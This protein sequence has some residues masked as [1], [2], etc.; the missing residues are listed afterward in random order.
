MLAASKT[1]DKQEKDWEVEWWQ[2]QPLLDGTPSRPVEWSTCSLI[3][4]A[5]HTDPTLTARHFSSSKQFTLPSPDNSNSAHFLAAFRPPSLISAAPTGDW[6]FAYYPGNDNENRCCLWKRG[7][8]IDS[9]SVK[10]FWHEPSDVI[11]AEWIGL[12]REWTVNADG[13]ASR[14]PPFGPQMP[15]LSP[16][17]I[18]IT[19]NN[20]L[21]LVYYRQYQMNMK[22][23]PMTLLHQCLNV[24]A[25]LVNDWDNISIPGCARLCAKA[26]IGVNYNDPGFMIATRVYRAPARDAESVAAFQHDDD[27]QNIDW[28]QWGEESNIQIAEGVIGFDGTSVHLALQMSPPIYPRNTTPVAAMAFANAV[29]KAA[30][31]HK[32][33][34]APGERFLVVS[35]LDFG[36]YT[37]PPK[38]E[39][40]SYSFTPRI[41]PLNRQW[42]AK[43]EVARSFH[44]D[45]VVSLAPCKAPVCG[46]YATVLHRSGKFPRGREQARIGQIMMLNTPDLSDSPNA[47][48]S[49]V[50]IP[51][52]HISRQLP[53]HAVM[54]PNGSLSCAVSSD[55][56]PT[57]INVY[58]LPR[59]STDTADKAPDSTDQEIGARPSSDLA[60]R[61]VSAI[62]SQ[63]R[64]G[65]LTHLLAVPVTPMDTVRD[66]LA[67]VLQLLV[68]NMGVW[69]RVDSQWAVLGLAVEV[70]RSRAQRVKDEEKTDF[71]LRWRAG[72][73]MCSLFAMQLA[74]EYCA[75]EEGKYD[76]AALWQLVGLCTWF[77]GYLERLMKV[78]VQHGNLAAPEKATE[79]DDLFG[80]LPSPATPSSCAPA[81]ADAAPSPTLLPFTHVALVETLSHVAQQVNKLRG[82][83]ETAQITDERSFMAKHVLVD[84][85]DCAG[86]SLKEM[87]P[88]LD[89][90]KTMVADSIDETQQRLSLV[91]CKPTHESRQT[92]HAIA[93]KITT[94]PVLDKMRLFIRPADLVDGM[95]SMSLTGFDASSLDDAGTPLPESSSGS[96]GMR[97]DRDR[98]VV[99]KAPLGQQPGGLVCLR[100]G[101]RSDLPSDLEDKAIACQGWR[102]WEGRWARECICGGAWIS[103]AHA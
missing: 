53:L 78:T 35:H 23:M 75:D 20:C 98:D 39:L 47:I 70:Y 90:V 2:F 41:L 72:R 21:K 16:A 58:T 42:E 59:C 86:V 4:T 48:P 44:P 80:S 96:S 11:A 26:A 40:V 18:L 43:E 7:S 36:D 63:R 49:P 56:M 24:E 103:A 79:E 10:D 91:S 87:E 28:E 17:L 33:S 100:C 30:E 55:L 64:T 57:R 71:G 65:D 46:I 89:E 12:P 66:T 62:Y 31:G 8:T 68:K 27:L 73:D 102:I 51:V 97:K 5:H 45:I 94:S 69:S 101:G 6:L 92:V 1:K 60:R 13:D 34:S 25:N 38:S 9:W 82:Q 74:F 14:L 93:R 22:I 83:V 88:L 81:V 54:S 95:G 19:R 37:S 85:I 61:I 3:F 29:P 67:E 84:L 52:R 32:A 50:V 99:T 15:V 77:M 76:L